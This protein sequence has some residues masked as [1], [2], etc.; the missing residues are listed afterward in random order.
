M[1]IIKSIH[2]S[3]VLGNIFK[4]NEGIRAYQY[5]IAIMWFKYL[6]IGG[7]I[8]VSGLVLWEKY[9]WLLKKG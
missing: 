9:V 8:Q 3:L 2:V 7:I 4:D 6:Y 5:N 1:N